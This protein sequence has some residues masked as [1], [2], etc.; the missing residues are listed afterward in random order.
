MEP[1]MRI[2]GRLLRPSTLAERR[3]LLGCFA[4]S[5]LR[6]PR[7]HNIFDIARRVDRYLR[8]NDDL[9]LLRTIAKRRPLPPVSPELD[10]PEHLP[11]DA[12]APATE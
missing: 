7:S 6:I 10:T 9:A 4:T 12:H 11:V 2:C 3:L 8:R 5:T 1:I